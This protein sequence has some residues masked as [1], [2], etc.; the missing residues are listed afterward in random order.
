MREDRLE[1]F[2]RSTP[3]RAVLMVGLLGVAAG[4]RLWGITWGLPDETHLFSYH[5]DEYH[6]LRGALSLAAGDPNP[7]FFNYGSLYLYL[8][9]IVC[10]WHDAVLGGADL[11]S[12]LLNG[13]TA[14]V[15]MAAWVLDARLVV[16]ACGVATVLVVFL[17]GRRLWG[18]LGGLCAGGVMAILPLHVLNSHY[19]TVDV[20]QAL[21]ITLCLYFSVRLVEEPTWR[22][23][24]WAGVCAGL[25][26]SV[27]YNG[28]AVLVAPV[29]AHV[30]QG[31]RN[32]GRAASDRLRTS[33]ESAP[34]GRGSGLE[35]PLTDSEREGS[36]LE[37]PLTDSEREPGADDGR[38][39]PFGKAQGKQVAS[40]R[41]LVGMAAVA[42]LAFALTSPYVFL[43]WPEA[44]RDI[45]FEIGHMRAGESPAKEAYPNGWVFHLHPALLFM[46]LAL[47]LVRGSLRWKLLPCAAFGL[48]WFGMVG[49]AGVRYARYEVPLEPLLAMGAATVLSAI[50]RLRWVEVRWAGAV[51]LGLWLIAMLGVTIQRDAVMQ[52]SDARAEML[53]KVL[54]TVPEGEILA[55]AWEPWFNIAPVDYCNGGEALRG[56]PLFARFKRP[57][58][59]LVVTG[60]DAERIQQEQPYAVLISNF[61]LHTAFSR[62]SPG[63]AA[64]WKLLHDHRRFAP[65]TYEFQPFVTDYPLPRWTASDSHYPAPNQWLFVRK[66]A[67]EGQDTSEGYGARRAK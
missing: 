20:P 35:A 33:L 4:V 14:H 49:A 30:V 13:A 8:V 38:T 21:F 41:F 59:P 36:G 22:N 31:L 26:A 25:A 12:A 53:R 40:L 43:A 29:V 61:E 15:E 66:A 18:M 67:Q 63:H 42:A 2:L 51:V 56:N 55:V 5:P 23:Y 39:G 50:W 11:L 28:I 34:A 17:I 1:K 19:A 54:D 32:G 47:L 48:L 6:S 60:V 3:G 37:A 57:V 46:A 24:L 7:H 52:S 44:W 10:L 62:V 58:R 64:V 65:V 16:V 27:K 9:G 45:S